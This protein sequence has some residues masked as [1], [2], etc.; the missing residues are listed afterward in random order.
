MPKDLFLSG[1]MRLKGIKK[2]FNRILLVKM[3]ILKMY[4]CFYTGNIVFR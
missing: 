4:S 1:C 2:T 3:G